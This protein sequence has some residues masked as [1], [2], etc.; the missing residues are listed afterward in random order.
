MSIA[1]Q[2]AGLAGAYLAGAVPTGFLIGKWFAGVDL[3]N[4][5]S[6]NIGFT[7]AVRVLGWKLGA[8]VLIID[9]GKAAAATALIPRHVGAQNPAHYMILAGLAV[10]LGNLFNVFLGFKGG[11]GAATALG[12]FLA[13]AP[14]EILC[15]FGAFL[16]VVAITRFVSLGSIVAAATMTVLVGVLRG[17]RDPLFWMTALA[18]GGIIFKHRANIRRLI[19]GTES[20]IGRAKP[21]STGN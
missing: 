13:L 4:E 7:N 21:P 1:L 6:K 10:L 5:G 3:R 2:A 16:L 9:V 15:A 20:R 18:A 19:D 11:K 14:K 12:V 17:P 8:P